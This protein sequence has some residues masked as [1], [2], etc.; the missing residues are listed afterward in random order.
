M[1]PDFGFNSESTFVK[2][3]L[4]F[5]LLTPIFYI[6][7]IFSI[8]MVRKAEFAADRYS[9][10]K[11]YGIYLREGLI[12]LFLKNSGNMNPDWLFALLKYSHP[13]LVERIAAIDEHIKK[14]GVGHVDTT[15]NE[16]VD[17]NDPRE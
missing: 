17:V 15:S 5:M 10:E 2:L 14:L 9:V 6:L 8:L 7:D 16:G 1:A 11:G 4:F 13:A 3:Y 12:K